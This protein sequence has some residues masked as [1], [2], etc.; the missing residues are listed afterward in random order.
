M[1]ENKEEG[2]GESDEDSD[3]S[4]D[5]KI[6]IGKI[7]TPSNMFGAGHRRLPPILGTPGWYG[8]R[9]LQPVILSTFLSL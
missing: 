5:V 7:M 8:Y 4:D 3:D 9:F 1:D 2:R 6:T